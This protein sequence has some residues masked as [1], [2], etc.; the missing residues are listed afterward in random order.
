MAFQARNIL[1]TVIF[2][3]PHTFNQGN[4]V[5]LLEFLKRLY[6][7]PRVFGWD[8]FGEAS[9]PLPTPRAGHRKSQLPTGRRQR[10]LRGA[11][12]LFGDAAPRQDERHVGR[13]GFLASSEWSKG[14]TCRMFI[15]GVWSRAF[16]GTRSKEHRL[17]L[18]HNVCPRSP[19]IAAA[20][21]K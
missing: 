16:F 18:S 12:V 1:N 20:A 6:R 9:G 5:E 10:Q 13:F 17:F 15:F 19:Y 8:F 11:G 2:I 3:S 4:I 7:T 14:K 21:D